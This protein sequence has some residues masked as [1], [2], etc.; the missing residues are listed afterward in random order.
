MTALQKLIRTWPFTL[1]GVLSNL[2]FW[3]LLLLPEGVAENSWV[4][5]PLSP[6]ILLAYLPRLFLGGVAE[7]LFGSS[8]SPAWFGGLALVL[9]LLP[10]VVVD[11]FRAL[12]RWHADREWKAIIPP[13]RS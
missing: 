8:G 1:V 5:L 3:V 6:F 13:A 9:P 2:I 11:G 4:R 7:Q 10:F 12:I